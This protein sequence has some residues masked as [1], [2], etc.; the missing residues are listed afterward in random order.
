MR[1]KT[2]QKEQAAKGRILV[3]EDEPDIQEL[4]RY[5]IAREGYKVSCTE[6]GSRGIRMAQDERPDLVLLDLMLPDVDGLEVC[7]VLKGDDQTRGIPLVMLTAKGEESDIVLGLE[8]GADDYVTK[9]F[10]PRVLLAR[11]RAVLRSREEVNGSNGDDGPVR[12]G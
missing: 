11:L 10:S 3:V 4:L 9:P 6:S 5:N 12:V 2:K 8:M 1:A 7:R